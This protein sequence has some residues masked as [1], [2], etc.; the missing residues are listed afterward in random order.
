MNFKETLR[1]RTEEAE[2]IVR[3]FLPKEEGFPQKL[4]EAM[5]YSINAGGK[6]I[7]PLIMKEV[8][9][10]SGGKGSVIEPFM[11]AIEMIHTYSL[12][13]DDLP[14]LDNDMY[15]R[16]KKTTHAVY[17]EALGVLTG[18]ALENYAFETALGS[19]ERA[20]D[21]AGKENIIQAMKI[22]SRKAGVYGML[23]GQSVDVQNEKQGNLILSREELDFIYLNKTSALLE[24]SMMIG[25]VLAG[26]ADKEI[27]VW[28]EIGRRIGLAF[29]IRDDVLDVTSTTEV[30][31]KPVFSDEENGKTTY[32]TLYGAERAAR[33]A[34]KLTEEALQ[35][36]SQLPGDTEFMNMLCLYLAQREK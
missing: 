29:Q 33:E 5:N 18:A 21:V 1:S 20:K 13:H 4:L 12:V 30:L 10:L 7:R 27:T 17:G 8:F 16:G 22:L 24:A 6:R 14:A 34:D 35:L 15:R 23:G 2:Q 28:E 32:V 25:A 31:G 19:F 36:L 26:A 3:S 11:A 9:D